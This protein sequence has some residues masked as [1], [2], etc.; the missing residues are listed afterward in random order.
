MTEALS[1]ELTGYIKES[2]FFPLAHQLLTNSQN[3][4]SDKRDKEILISSFVK[5]KFK[6]E[7]ES[8]D[9]ANVESHYR[10]LC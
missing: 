4:S 8:L 1:Q 6:Y 5:D 3:F 10:Q 7:F 2:W 9:I